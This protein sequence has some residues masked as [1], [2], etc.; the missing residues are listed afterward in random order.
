V[1]AGA[2][3]GARPR[4]RYLNRG[5]SMIASVGLAAAGVLL[6]T[7]AASAWWALREK[8]EMTDD[9]RQGHVRAVAEQLSHSAE[10]FL[11]S[12]DLSALRRAVVATRRENA[13]TSVRVSLTDGRVLADSDPLKITP[14]ELPPK[15][16]TGPLDAEAD[17]P[18]AKSQIAFRR[19]LMIPGR[20]AAILEVSAPAVTERSSGWRLGAGLGLLCTAGLAALWLVYRHTRAKVRS[21][22]LIR[23]ALLA[24]KAGERCREALEIS[25]DEGPEAAAWNDLLLEAETLRKGTLLAQ[26]SQG[27]DRRKEAKS[28]LELACDSLSVGMILLDVKGKVRHVNG[29]AASLLGAAREKLVGT[30]GLA[31]VDDPEIKAAIMGIVTGTSLQRR[32]AEVTRAHAGAE[33][34]RTGNAGEA[35]KAD[36]DR[37]PASVLR[38]QVRP[39]RREDTC[40]AMLTIE[41]VTQ[42]RVAEAARHTF[43]AQAT[44]ELRTP[45]TNMRLCL[46][47]AI[48]DGSKDAGVLAKSLNTLNNE[49]RRLE[50]M[51]SE[52]LSVAEI[53]AGSLE[54]H[55]G[56]VRLD[57]VF[58]ALAAD[59]DAPAKE[60]RIDLKFNLPP[61]IPVIQA[62][63]DK[64]VLAIH[65][66][67]G[68]AIKYTPAGGKVTV[69]LRADAQEVAVQVTDTGIGISEQDQPLVFEKFYRAKDPRVEKVTGSGLGL[70][71]AMEV[72]KLH[73]GGI[74]LNSKLDQGSTFTLTVPVSAQPSRRAA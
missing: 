32:T 69:M 31:L 12:N 41:D 70:A 63:R 7:M 33:Q 55:A 44:H 21:L 15:F 57:A 68:N 5:E 65:N 35:A 19:P 29:A 56:D 23:E 4:S 38:V 13:L 42:L 51:V 71:L 17:A 28:E 6:L 50:R 30:E 72:A 20:G 25:A 18:E 1:A 53:E 47:T 73:G 22:A 62:D 16:P 54:L 46:E 14:G 2:S 26:L 10:A 24:M 43:V 58:E 64:L 61:K 39:L 66:L 59:F 52:M 48:E 8:Q 36:P 37:G 49:T 27:P 34:A 9:V 3:D 60:K 45:L 40:S 67:I 11:G 74:T